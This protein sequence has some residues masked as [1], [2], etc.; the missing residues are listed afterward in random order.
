MT[1][2][3]RLTTTNVLQ[4]LANAGYNGCE[5]DKAEFV[6]FNSSNEAVYVVTYRDDDD[7]LDTGYL[8]VTMK[9]GKLNAE[10]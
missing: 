8:F 2:L 6:R 9:N 4:A 1:D 7:K 3:T 5:F 10:F